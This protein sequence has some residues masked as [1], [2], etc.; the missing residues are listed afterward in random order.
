MRLPRPARTAACFGFL[1][2]ASFTAS[3]TAADPVP[4]WDPVRTTQPEDLAE[5]KALQANV[6]DVVT[7][8]TPVTVAI[9]FGNAAGSGVIVN[10]DGLVLTAAHVIRDYEVSKKGKEKELPYTSGK[11]V[12]MLLPDGTKIEGKTL[13]INGDIIAGMDSGMIQI[14]TKGPN[15]GKWPFAPL[16]K[17]GTVEKGQWVVSLG[18]PNGPKTERPPV[19]RLGRV[20]KAD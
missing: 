19:A 11:K 5:L 12:Q 13:G 8:C 15:N 7:K 6:N 20:L 2:V 9:L 3:T 10:E 4:K 16:A 18:H 14:T 1:L 17:A